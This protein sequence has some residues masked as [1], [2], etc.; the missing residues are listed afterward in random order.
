MLLRRVLCF[1]GASLLCASVLAIPDD[2]EEEQSSAWRE[3]A[4]Q[5][6]GPPRTENLLPFYVSAA[7]SN[8]FFVDAASLDVGSD[9]VVRYTL[10]VLTPEGGRNVTFEG[11]RCETRER[12]IYASGRLDGSWSRSRNSQWSRFQDAA[13]NRQYAALFLDHL[14]RDGVIARNVEEIVTSLKRDAHFVSGSR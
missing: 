12:R 14:C 3:L 5:L 1:L 6:P 8:S 4:W 7:S 9:G 11:M 2:E 10:L 13:A